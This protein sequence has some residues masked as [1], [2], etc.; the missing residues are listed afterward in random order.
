MKRLAID[1]S[2]VAC[3]V[4]LQIG[5]QIFERHEE[6]ARE[7]TR[8]LM[9]MIRDVL[10]DA[11]VALSDLDA[12]VLGNGPG[13]FIG[14]RIAA[15]VSQ[16]LAHGAGLKII[17]V[18]SLSAVAAEV[19]EKTDANIVAVSQ[20]AHMS[21]VYL[22]VFSRDQNNLPQAVCDERLHEQAIVD[23]LKS[24]DPDECVLAGQGWERYPMLTEANRG[25]FSALLEIHYPRAKHLL[26]LSAEQL[27]IAPQDIQPAYLRQKV[28]MLPKARAPR[29]HGKN[30]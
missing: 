11:K 21:E 10:D 12:I 28:A 22:G 1:T 23:E 19:F 2:S 6:Q 30:Q 8:L 17:P 27:P 29:D 3:T 26:S 24:C 9:P 15:S 18:S 25:L 4:A 7:H 13:S 16:G 14:M 20:D 5:D